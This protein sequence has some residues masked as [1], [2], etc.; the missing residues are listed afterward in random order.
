MGETDR[1]G[2]PTEGAPPTYREPATIDDRLG[3]V[4]WSGQR[5]GPFTAVALAILAPFVLGGLALAAALAS[6][7]LRDI[8]PG[9]G[10][11]LFL[12]LGSVFLSAMLVPGV[13]RA[14]RSH[15]LGVSV[16][17]RGIRTVRRGRIR[18]VLLD[19]IEAVERF[20]EGRAVVVA[21]G[22]ERLAIDLP[23]ADVGLI[24]VQLV[25]GRLLE[26]AEAELRRGGTVHFGELEVTDREVVAPR[27]RAPWSALTVEPG[28]AGMAK[29]TGEPHE[30]AYVRS[31]LPNFDVFLLLYE[32][33][34]GRTPPVVV[35][36][37]VLSPRPLRRP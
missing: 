20:S 6:G 36:G 34:T 14:L 29:L 16:H 5:S 26:Q 37:R 18:E 3:E 4:L 32:R 17:E 19:D 7:A 9:R 10:L 24:V 25:A 33:R 13:I 11:R 30:I 15:G 12:G 27:F 22:G 21:R 23:W 31:D 28:L 2:E 1:R 8:F 35:D